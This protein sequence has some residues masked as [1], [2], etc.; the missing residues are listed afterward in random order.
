MKKILFPTD[1]SAASLNAFVYAIDLAKKI[2]AEIITLHVFDLPADSVTEYYNSVLEHY[3]I[4]EWSEF[5]NY[6]GEVP[7]LRRIAEDHDGEHIKLSHVLEKGLVADTI[8]EVAER[9][10][11]DFIV[12]GTNGAGGIVEAILGSVT[13]K[14]MNKSGIMTLAIPADCK[15]KP[16]SKILLLTKF[17]THHVALWNKL[18]H[19][20]RMFGAHIDVLHVKLLRQDGDNEMLEQLKQQFFPAKIDFHIVY[21]DRTEHAIV[22]F[23]K[24]NKIDLVAM[25]V[26]R[27]GLIDRIFFDSLARKMAFHSEIPVMSVKKE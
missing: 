17:E 27:K 24:T 12:M 14:V 21:S 10:K 9:N 15:F 4:S 5:E 23:I 3:E 22:Q 8:V 19:F 7:M 13:E 20:A 1:F 26:K 18:L 16:F 2:G 25:S 6:K 11:A